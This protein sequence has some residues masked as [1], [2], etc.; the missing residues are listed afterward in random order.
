MLHVVVPPAGGT[1]AALVA[2][3]T[4]L[5]E[6][7]ARAL[8]NLGA[9]YAGERDAPSRA[10][11]AA[12]HVAGGA[13]LR[14]HARPRRYAAARE[15]DWPARVLHRE[16]GF[17][18]VHKPS[19]LPVSPGVD[20]SREC[21]A[22]CVA[23][24]LRCAP[25]RVIHRLDNCTSGVLALA[26][27]K[28]AAQRFGAMQRAAAGSGDDDEPEAAVTKLYRALVT[29]P[30][31]L[32]AQEAWVTTGH[33]EP[34]APRRTLV[35]D[36][37]GD[38]RQRAVQQVLACAPHAPGVWECE[39]RLQTGRTHQIRAL[40]AASGAPIMGDTLYGEPDP[41]GWREPD[42][43]ALHAGSL[44]MDLGSGERRAFAAPPPWATA[45]S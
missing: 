13:H 28:D 20:N 15:T 17:V 42:A 24:A 6:T 2:S 36:A 26:E 30:V 12:L 23:A 45:G 1:L 35:F 33:K 3:A 22:A 16:A 29:A 21:V 39:V 31:A 10:T 38:G 14:I 41:R 7:E 32:G 34:G 18:V 37:P 8:I 43:I 27:T 5:A 25:L 19:G 4:G 9:V 11:K 44:E 40:L